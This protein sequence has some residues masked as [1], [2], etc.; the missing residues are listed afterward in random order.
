MARRRLGLT[1][2]FVI[3]LIV[4]AGIVVALCAQ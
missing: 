1:G 4:V 3:W 2:A